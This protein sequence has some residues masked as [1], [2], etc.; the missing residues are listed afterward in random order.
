MIGRRL[1][2][3][4]INVTDERGKIQMRMESLRPEGCLKNGHEQRCADS[5]AGHVA[6]RDAPSSI[7]QGDEVVVVAADSVGRLV[8]GFAGDAR[9]G[10]VAR[11]EKCL[12]NIPRAFQI[13][14]ER[15]LKTRIRFGSFEK[16]QERLDV[17]AQKESGFPGCPRSRASRIG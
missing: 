10:E 3:Q 9:D 1:V 7:G 13:P 2:D 14:A 6:N 5:F 4:A 17:I 8:E 12:L 16:L 15:S 11:R